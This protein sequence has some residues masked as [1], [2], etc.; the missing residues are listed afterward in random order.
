SLDER[1][2]PKAEAFLLTCF[3]H[4]DALATIKS[5]QSGADLNE[6]VAYLLSQGTEKMQRRLVAEHK[7]L[8]GGMLSYALF[9]ASATLT[10]EEFYEGFSPL[11]DGLSEKRTKKNS[12]EHDRGQALLTALNSVSDVHPYFHR[13]WMDRRADEQQGRA[14]SLPELDPRWLD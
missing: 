6:L 7:T 4:A 8:V 12:A 2:D 11:L 1:S 9:A 14:R 5:E 13:S 3:E 10:P